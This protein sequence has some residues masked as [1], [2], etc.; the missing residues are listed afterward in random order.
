[1]ERII[2]V[3]EQRREQYKQH[4]FI[5]GLLDRTIPSSHRLAYAPFA[6][7]FIMTFS[8][9]NKYFLRDENNA[10]FCQ[11]IVNKH[12]EEDARHWEWFL[13]D[14]DTLGWNPQCKFTDSLRFIWNGLGRYT[15]EMGYWTISVARDSSPELRLV[16]IEA[17]EAMGN[18]WLSST[19]EAARNHPLYDQLIYFGKYHL[20]RET[21]H[22]IGSNQNDLHSMVLG[23][24]IR[25]KAEEIVHGLFQRMEDFNSE[26]LQR[27]QRVLAKGTFKEFIKY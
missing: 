5:Q 21:G 6:C 15:R 7:H 26:I 23:D 13:T 27:S 16:M 12:T 11:T 14:L 20:E 22:A 19:V 25:I 18:V 9:I 3:I 1:M 8:E 24:D 17:L 10:N 2:K 4:P